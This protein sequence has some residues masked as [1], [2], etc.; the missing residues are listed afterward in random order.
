MRIAEMLARSRPSVSFEFMA[1]RDEAEV[2]LLEKTGATLAG[3][4]PDWVAVT[5][6]VRTGEKALE[7]VTR[8]NRHYHIQAMSH[9][10]SANSADPTRSIRNLM[11]RGGVA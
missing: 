7:L 6:L 4:A 3:H 9:L 5:Y 10:T 11:D 1:P 2:E 8:I